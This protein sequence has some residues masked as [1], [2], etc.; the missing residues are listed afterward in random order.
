[1]LCGAGAFDAVLEMTAQIAIPI[2]LG[3]VLGTVVF[4]K[5]FVMFLSAVFGAGLL[6][7][8]MTVPALT[9]QRLQIGQIFRRYE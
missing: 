4:R 2:L 1:M 7:V 8:I 9:W 6:L 3:I 5:L